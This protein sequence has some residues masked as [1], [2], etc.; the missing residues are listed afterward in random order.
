MG[1]EA[2][3]FGGEYL[4]SKVA[5]LFQHTQTQSL[6]LAHPALMERQAPTVGQAEMQPR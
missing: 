5:I 3:R 2:S 4:L 6:Y 1:N